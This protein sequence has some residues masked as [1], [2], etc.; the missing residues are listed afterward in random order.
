MTMGVGDW[1]RKR[2]RNNSLYTPPAHCCINHSCLSIVSQKAMPHGHCP[3]FWIKITLNQVSH[4]PL[5]QTYLQVPVSTLG[6]SLLRGKLCWNFHF[7]WKRER[8]RG[9]IRERK[10][11]L[12]AFFSANRTRGFHSLSMRH[13]I[14]SFPHY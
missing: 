2:K 13:Y 4:F 11:N 8:E 6:T 5:L 12:I 7:L 9:E 14:Y 10:E 3:K 1:I